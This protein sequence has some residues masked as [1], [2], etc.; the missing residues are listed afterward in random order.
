MKDNHRS[1]NQPNFGDDI[2]ERCQPGSS[3]Y[4]E[5]KHP[6]AEPIPPECTPIPCTSPSYYDENDHIVYT[7]EDG[8]P[9]KVIP[10]RVDY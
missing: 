4:Q 8:Q 2:D 6:W 1:F 10:E 5:P 9:L 7:D 3:V